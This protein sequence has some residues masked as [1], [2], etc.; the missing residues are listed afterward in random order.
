VTAPLRVEPGTSA[1]ITATFTAPA[2]AKSGDVITGMLT[3]YS[4]GGDHLGMVPV[5][6]TIE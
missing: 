4:S 1:T 3:F 6:A 2:T 5:T